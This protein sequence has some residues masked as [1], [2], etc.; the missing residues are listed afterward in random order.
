MV[1]LHRHQLVWLTESAWNNVR[2][3]A[4][5]SQARAC[6]DHWAAHRLP[7]V[8]TRQPGD[9][10]AGVIAVALSAPVR[11]QRRRL[12]L[13]IARS[14]VA[15]FDE[16][17]AAEKAAALLP[18]ALQ[19]R[20]DSL[21]AQLTH[22]GVTARVYG[23]YGWQLLSGLDHVRASS[24][25]DLWLSV[26]DG[27]QADAAAECLRQFTSET[28]HVDGEIM[29]NEGAAVAWR[30]WLSWR[31]GGV[32]GLL[33]KTLDACSLVQTPALQGVAHVDRVPRM[34]EPA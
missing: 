2:N 15:Y 24:D 16:F 5:D 21:C 1:S 14:E 20:W 12:A 34:V 29:F 22:A 31:S 23:S 3:R 8:I 28:V 25:I 6:I 18:D 30:E 19:G 33:I 9:L 13:R 17:P 27:K 32:K 26:S 7:L 4:W 11:W 10:E